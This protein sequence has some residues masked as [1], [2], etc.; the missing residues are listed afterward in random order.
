MNWTQPAVWR[1]LC[2]YGMAELN[3]PMDRTKVYWLADGQVHQGTDEEYM[4]HALMPILKTFGHAGA[5]FPVP[6]DPSVRA[7]GDDGS[8]EQLSVSEYLDHCALSSYDRDIV[9]G[10]LGGLIHSTETA[11]IAQLL[12]MCAIHSGMAGVTEAAGVWYPK[13]GTKALAEAILKDAVVAGAQ[14]RLSTP[15][16]AIEQDEDTVSG[17]VTV[18]TASGEPVFARTAVVALPINTLGHVKMTPALPVDVSAMLDAR[19]PTR[20]M[21]LWVQVKGHIE[22]FAALAPP[23][24]HPLNNVRAEKYWGDDTLLLCMVSDAS[25]IDPT[26][27]VAVA[28]ALHMFRPDL[29]V[30]ATAH[31][32][33]NNDDFS[34]GAWMIHRPG[35]LFKGAVAIR[36]PHGRVFFA[37]ADIAALSPACIDGAISSGFEAAAKAAQLLSE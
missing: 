23:G 13:H 20:A 28:A 22:G 33:W 8:T 14:L 36:E 32:D 6:F 24:K 26:N 1:E 31:H 18:T 25:S 35:H 37:G 9:E 2:K 30:I 11:G 16:S 4:E 34:Q 3:K 7:P 19:N 12:Q 17:G 15:V 27:L 21:K 5:L 10:I 29:E